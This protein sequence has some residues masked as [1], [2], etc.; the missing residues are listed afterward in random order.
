MALAPAEPIGTS[1]PPSLCGHRPRS[2]AAGTGSRRCA[3]AAHGRG[4]RRRV[5]VATPGRGRAGH[6]GRDEPALVHTRR[7][8]PSRFG[9]GS[10]YSRVPSSG[11]TIHTRSAWST[12]ESSRLLGEDG[13]V[14][15][16]A[17]EHADDPARAPRRSPIARRRWGCASRSSSSLRNSTRQLTG[18]GSDRGGAPMVRRRRRHQRRTL[19]AAECGGDRATRSGVGG[20]RPPISRCCWCSWRSAAGPITPGSDGAGFVRRAVAVRG[21]P[22]RRA[23]SSPAWRRRRSPGGDRCPHGS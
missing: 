15:P 1:R 2:R 8:R 3:A 21:G 6:G 23:G 22:R 16:F 4:Q 11:S 5:S 18:P 14:G 17:G 19:A 20:C 12:P 10:P 13:I 7:G 9:R